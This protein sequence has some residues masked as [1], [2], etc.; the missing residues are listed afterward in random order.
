MP[1]PARRAAARPAC[2]PDA[3]GL[4]IE[5]ITSPEALEALRDDWARLFAADPA[6]SPFQHPAWLLAWRRAFLDG[7]GLW[8]LALRRSGELVGLAPFFI[9][10]DPA[11]GRRQLTLLGNGLSDRQGLLVRPGAREAV[12]EAVAAWLVRSRRLWDAVDFRDLP[13]GSPLLEIP[14]P[15]RAER[16]EAEAPCPTLELPA[17]AEAMLARLPRSRRTDL[18]RCARRLG[19]I[20]PLRLTRADAAS[21]GEHLA[22][23]ARLHGARWR[24]RGE[25]GV[26]SEEAVLGF[27]E[28]ATAGLL[29][30][31]L[32]RLEALR[33]GERVVAV[34]YGLRRGVRGYS[35]LHAFDPELAAFGPGWLL[36]AESLAAAAREGVRRFDFLRGREP[37]KYAWGGRDQPQ[38]RRRIRL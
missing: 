30:A 12:L 24:A 14:L 33:L 11:S 4:R 17:D 8:C 1:L 23:L 21:R 34:H 13:D 31:G 32:L 25:A 20:A 19:E 16:I 9:W 2:A 10:T 37:Y 27:H 18:R 29:A 22:A 3:A 15:G 28:A 36:M 6:A 7:P 26:L 35:Y 5:E 38:W